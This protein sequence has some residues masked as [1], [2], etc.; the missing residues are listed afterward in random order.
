VTGTL[1]IDEMMTM[2]SLLFRKTA[3]LKKNQYCEK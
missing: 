1:K 2:S 3:K